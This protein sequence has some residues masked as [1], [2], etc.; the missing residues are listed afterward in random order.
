MR[1]TEASLR[2]LIRTLI[3]EEKKEIEAWKPPWEGGGSGSGGHGHDRHWADAGSSDGSPLVSS[4]WQEPANTKHT[5]MA[6]ALLNNFDIFIH[7]LLQR[8]VSKNFF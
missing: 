6:N 1:I 3:L 8:R 2:A 7:D 4:D 5:A